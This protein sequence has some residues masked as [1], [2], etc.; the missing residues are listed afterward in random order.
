MRPQPGLAQ[1]FEPVMLATEKY[2]PH[3]TNAEV[4]GTPA[5]AV[6]DLIERHPAY[7]Q[8]W[9]VLGRK[10][11]QIALSNGFN[12]NPVP[13]EAKL[14]Q[15]PHILTA[16]VFGNARIELGILVDP[17]S[18]ADSSGHE[19]D[20]EKIKDLIWPTVESVNVGCKS[21]A[22]IRREMILVASPDK[23]PERTPKGTAKRRICLKMYAKEIEGL[24]AAQVGVCP[25]ER[26]FTERM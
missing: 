14:I 26:P 4:D 1:T 25:A 12:I 21:Y 11:D 6:G 13:I 20:A 17:V 24:Y 18:R 23:P 7:S 16:I 8:L 22:R 9:R 3:I 2:F 15:D 5:F 19:L 10:D